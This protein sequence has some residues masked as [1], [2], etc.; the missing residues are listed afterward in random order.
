MHDLSRHFITQLRSRAVHYIDS[1]T[2]L[3][4]IENFA[5]IYC[6]KVFNIVIIEYILLESVFSWI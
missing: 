3:L 4:Y 6:S 1:S 5:D 2:P